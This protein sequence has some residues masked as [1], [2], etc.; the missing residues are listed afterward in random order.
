MKKEDLKKDHQFRARIV[1]ELDG[2]D[3]LRQGFD[4]SPEFNDPNF[5]L[6]SD[7]FLERIKWIAKVLQR[8]LSRLQLVFPFEE[9]IDSQGKPLCIV[10]E[11]PYKPIMENEAGVSL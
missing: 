8:H 3:I 1:I 9:P 5:K 6:D 2:K 7:H 10:C 11:Q 4:F